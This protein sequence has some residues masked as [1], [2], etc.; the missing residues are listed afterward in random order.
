MVD[1]TGH[2]PAGSQ[3]NCNYGGDIYCGNQR[4]SVTNGVQQKI[5]ERKKWNKYAYEASMRAA[6][7]GVSPDARPTGYA[8]LDAL[9]QQA[10]T[11][12]DPTPEMKLYIDWWF[13]TS[14][15]K[16]YFGP[17][18]DVARSL[19]SARGVQQQLAKYRNSFANL[20][21][22]DQGNFVLDEY[23][24]YGGGD[25]FRDASAVAG[26]DWRNGFYGSYRVKI[27]S[28]SPADPLTVKVEVINPTSWDSGTR[29]S[30]MPYLGPFFTVAIGP[31]HGDA[32]PS[33][34]GYPSNGYLLVQ[35]VTFYYQYYD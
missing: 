24:N 21:K 30:A 6:A 12:S 18:S 2:D 22:D 23:F 31:N 3:N 33:A 4:P 27:S 19:E 14:E 11:S 13:G 9:F 10:V 1:P 28:V 15:R 35:D 26:G 25:H 34:Y 20:P 29:I 32:S 7:E 17:G 16:V 8:L 5:S